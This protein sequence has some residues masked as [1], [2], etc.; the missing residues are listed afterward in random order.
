MLV[1]VDSKGLADGQFR[2]KHGK[3]WSWF[4]SI[5]STGVTNAE[6]ACGKRADGDCLGKARRRREFRETTNQIS[7]GI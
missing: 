3:T 4:A 6:K 7:T 2:P 5:D 1:S